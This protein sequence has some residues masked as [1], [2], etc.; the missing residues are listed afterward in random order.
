MYVRSVG[1]VGYGLM[2][3]GVA[4]VSASD[5]TSSTLLL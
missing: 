2:G 4:Q 1:L 3:S 5:S